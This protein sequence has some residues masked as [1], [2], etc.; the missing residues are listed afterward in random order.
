MGN[1]CLS[2][3]TDSDDLVTA[4]GVNERLKNISNFYN[5]IILTI[6]NL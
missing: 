1:Y 3:N 6:L 2:K 5:K 4:S